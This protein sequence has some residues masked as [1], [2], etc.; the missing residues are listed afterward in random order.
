MISH[1][2]SLPFIDTDVQ[3]E[4]ETGKTIA[5]IF[6]ELGENAFRDLESEQIARLSKRLQPVVVSL[7]GGA[8][9][10]A[11]NRECIS[12]L[13]LTVWLQASPENI[14]DRI[15]KDTNTQS[16]RPKLSKLGD[17]DEIRTILAQR[18]A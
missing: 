14:C 15:S 13:G 11:E 17:L 5:E 10:R 16:R 3:I 12:Q 8:I 18:L 4:F 6:S 2:L 9:L 1:Q 7:G